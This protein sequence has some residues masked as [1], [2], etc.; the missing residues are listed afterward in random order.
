ME[1]AEGVEGGILLVTRILPSWLSYL[2]LSG[3]F[4]EA[5]LRPAWIGWDGIITLRH[6]VLFEVL[7]VAG[8]AYLLVG[9]NEF[10]GWIHVLPAAGVLGLGLWYGVGPLVAVILPLHLLIR[11]ATLWRDQQRSKEV[12]AALALSLAIMLL[13]RLAVGLLP[14]PAFGW[15]RADTP[16]TLWWNVITW[17]GWMRVP[18]A[19]PAWSCLYFLAMSLVQ[20]FDVRLT[21]WATMVDFV[22]EVDSWFEGPPKNQEPRS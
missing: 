19:L 2:V 15:T 4:L 18:H 13:L 17:H 22:E 16:T 5:W 3:L 10:L 11:A 21:R 9:R 1:T 20:I 14:F 8:L 12:F 6:L 7:G